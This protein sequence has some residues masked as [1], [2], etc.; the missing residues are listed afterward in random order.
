MTFRIFSLTRN[1]P[2]IFQPIPRIAIKHN[3]SKKQTF[4]Q[5]VVFIA[6]DKIIQYTIKKWQFNLITV[7]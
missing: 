3:H 2:F 4:V 6:I 5:T 1:P 7:F